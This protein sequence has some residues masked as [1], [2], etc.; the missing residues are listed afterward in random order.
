MLVR[1]HCLNKVVRDF[2]G[3]IAFMNRLAR[4]WKPERCRGGTSRF[5]T[6]RFSLVVISRGLR[7]EGE[8]QPG[9]C[10]DVRAGRPLT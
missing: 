6:S 1:I 2:D 5:F 4:T 3:L 8:D 10:S 9:F 7:L